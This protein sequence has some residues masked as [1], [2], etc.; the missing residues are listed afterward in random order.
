MIG[1]GGAPRLAMIAPGAFRL[2]LALAVVAS[3]LSRFDIGRLA[4]LLFFYLSGYWTARI[5][6]EKFASG[7]TLRF[8][9]ARYLRIVPLYLGAM[10]MAALV[11][12]R[13]FGPENLTLLGVASS[14]RDPLGISWSLDIELQFY[15]LLPFLAPLLAGPALARLAASLMIAAIGWWVAGRFGV[16]TVLQYLPAFVLGAMTFVHAWRPTEDAANSALVAFAAMSLATC[17]T[18]FIDKTVADPF[19]RDIFAFV[20]MLPILP[21]VARSLNAPSSKLDRHLGNLSFPLYLVHYPV[22]VL[23]GSWLGSGVKVQVV[24]AAGGML[25]ALAVYALADRPIDRW[26]VKIAG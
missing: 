6:A 9:L 17:L 4:V 10:L 8:Y 21:Y 24:G 11:L 15:L 3:H 13:E 14:D 1:I 18:P 22:I 5:W 25:L 2:I 12:A 26:R 19:D 7:Q 16:V 20:W 23:A